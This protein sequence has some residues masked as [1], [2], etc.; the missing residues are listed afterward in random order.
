[1]NN[2]YDGQNT[3]VLVEPQSATDTNIT[4][5]VVDISSLT[6]KGLILVNFGSNAGADEVTLPLYEGDTNVP[7]T[8]VEVLGTSL[9]DTGVYQYDIEPDARKQYIQLIP[10]VTGTVIVSATLSAPLKYV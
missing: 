4:G 9:G 8:L 1:M 2:C 3:L 10:Q 6:G 7:A 5:E